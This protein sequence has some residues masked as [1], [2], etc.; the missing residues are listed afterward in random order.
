MGKINGF[1]GTYASENSKGVYRFTFDTV[2]GTLGKP[3]LFYEAKDAKWI[4]LYKNIMAVPVENMHGPA[5]AFRYIGR[6]G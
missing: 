4:S 3:E 6:K 1:I 5:P 2:S